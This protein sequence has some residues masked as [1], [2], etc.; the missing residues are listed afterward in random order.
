[1]DL[2]IPPAP[3]F[4]PCADTLTSVRGLRAAG[5][6]AGLKASGNPDVGLL[7]ADVAVPAAAL[8]T[9]NHFAAAPVLVSRRHLQASG[10]LVR[11][12]VVNR[13]SCARRA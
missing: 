5:V 4:P 6:R 10:G 1:M 12:V 3:T 11:A 2:R 9:Q 13:C 7:V 8:F